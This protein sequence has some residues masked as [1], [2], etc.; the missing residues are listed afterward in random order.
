MIFLGRFAPPLEY[1]NLSDLNYNNKLSFTSNDLSI[2]NPRYNLQAQAT[3]KISGHWTSQ[4]ALS[5]GTAR[6]DGYYTYISDAEDG[7]NFALWA[8]KQQGQTTTTDIQQNFIGDFQIGSSATP[9]NG[10]PGL[11]STEILSTMAPAGIRCI[12]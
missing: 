10:R 11:L 12:P 7:A 4:T 5:R 8:N 2:K 1:H 3:Y 6:S 9:L